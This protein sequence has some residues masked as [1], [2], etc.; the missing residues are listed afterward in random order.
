MN[1]HIV[2]DSTVAFIIQNTVID[3]RDIV[4]PQLDPLSIGPIRGAEDICDVRKDFW[5]SVYKNA[6]NPGE[7]PPSNLSI[8]RSKSNELASADKIIIWFSP[9]IDDVFM[10]LWLVHA[11]EQLKVDM[12]KLFYIYIDKNTHNN[13][14][15]PTLSALPQHEFKN[16]INHEI[17]FTEKE[18]QILKDAWTAVQGNNPKKI[19]EIITN[20]LCR[21]LGI[22]RVFEEYSKR[23]PD[24]ETGVTSLDFRILEE[25]NKS[26]PKAVMILTE[27]VC[28]SSFQLVSSDFYVRSRFLELSSSEGAEALVKLTGSTTKLSDMSLELTSIGREVLEGKA[29]CLEINDIDEWIGG[30]HLNSAD[31]NIWVRDSKSGQLIQFQ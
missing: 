4:F 2:R 10:A 23:Y 13:E 12:N 1:C 7:I 6:G 31:G 24:R 28:D 11:L 5:E 29:N 8:L 20:E 26:G 27:I 21:L 16:Y 17:Q 3:E 19:N 14:S 30:V 15:V 25:I 22:N 18:I 9:N